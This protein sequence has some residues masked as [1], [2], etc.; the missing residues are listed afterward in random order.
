[1]ARLPKVID[2]SPVKSGPAAADHPAPV[3][4]E[5]PTDSASS[6]R[7]ALPAETRLSGPPAIRAALPTLPPGPGV[8]RM[9]D[10]RGGVLYVGKARSLKKR[11]QAYAN[12]ARQG[13]RIARMIA[14]AFAI[15]V[16]T[17]ETEAEALLLEANLIKR[18]KPRYNIVLRDDKSHPYI[19]L[20]GDHDWPQLVKH[21]GA[22]NRKGEY[23]G[24][25]ASAGAVTQTLNALQRAF[26]LRSC[27]DSV[28]DNRTRPCLQY[29]IKRCT[30]P[31]AELIPAADYAVLVGQARDFLAGKSREVHKQL[32]KRMQ[33]ASD[34]LQ[35]ETAAVLRD[36][37]RALAHVQSQQGINVDSIGDADIIAAEQQAGR[38]CIQVFFFRGGRNFGNRA[39]Y[40]SHGPDDTVETVLG[41]LLGQFYDTRKPPALVLL[42]HRLNNQDLVAEALSLRAGKTVTLAWPRRGDK[43]RLVQHALRNAREALARRLAESASQRS[44]LE[45]L[46]KQCDLEAVPERIE[47][48]DNSHIAG[49]DA[50][51]AMVVAGAQGF[52]KSAYRR[53]NIRQGTG[54]D[55]FQ[56]GDDYAMLRQVLT[57]RFTRLQHDDPDRG[58]GQW[59]DLVL[60]DGGAGQLSVAQQVFADLGVNGVAL[61]AIAKGPDRDAGREH[62][63]QPGR[64]P[65]TLPP[66]HPVL[67]FLQR[68]R[69]EAHRFAIGGHRG[70][71]AR[72]IVRSELDAIT[73]IGAKRKRALLHRFGSARAVGE[74][75]LADLETVDGIS[76]HVAKL[77][78]DHFH[79]GV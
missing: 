14:E 57:R 42:S 47:V 26:P 3:R 2:R 25:F 45:A 52:Q 37:I 35:F 58:G 29:Q 72:A 48:Y 11:V 30:G 59:P 44:L 13:Q 56:P 71:R 19:L 65:F 15:E 7:A 62:V 9:L 5:S 79:G 46:A 39:H 24:P 43:H 64:T 54:A 17:T 77:I 8:Y 50:V 70:Q 60:I 28:F 16:V 67:Y 1:M 20:T 78:Y 66:H 18:L 63:Y 4:R 41:A 55:G 38:T 22:R 32:A 23:F 69:D 36:R 21:R 12:P 33:A 40:P 76:R 53:F 68:L 51:G 73:G 49:R 75:G 31:C 27:S 61:A 34:A 10:R 6:E 74:A